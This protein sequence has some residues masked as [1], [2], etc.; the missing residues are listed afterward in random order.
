M[1]SPVIAYWTL[2][3]EAWA[4]YCTRGTHRHSEGVSSIYKGARYVT[5]T[6]RPM[7]PIGEATD[8]DRLVHRLDAKHRMALVAEFIWTGSAIERAK[9]LGCCVDTLRHR[10]RA[11]IFKLD[12]LH[13]A[14]KRSKPQ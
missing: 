13:Q 11:A 5:E 2:K 1:S 12:E 8:V 14:L 9:A 10:V 3:L 6:L 7:P 4:L